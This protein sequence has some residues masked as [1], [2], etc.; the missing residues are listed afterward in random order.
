MLDAT[1]NDE[2]SKDQDQVASKSNI[3]QITNLAY[4]RCPKN[5]KTRHLSTT[6]WSERC[7]KSEGQNG[8]FEQTWGKKYEKTRETQQNIA[9]GD[10]MPHAKGLVI[11]LSYL[12]SFDTSRPD[13]DCKKKQVLRSEVFPS[14][15]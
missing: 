2:H 12:P 1:K 9:D 8:S 5:E 11:R 6:I 14:A 10:L 3:V 4:P 7:E 15:F 13:L